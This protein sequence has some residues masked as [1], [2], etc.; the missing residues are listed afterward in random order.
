MRSD[1]DWSDIADHAETQARVLKWLRTLT[2]HDELEWDEDGDVA[3][4]VGSTRLYVR[5]SDD[6][7]VVRVYAPTL[8]EVSPSSAV[9]EELNRLNSFTVFPKWLMAGSTIIAAI[10]LYGSPLLKE[11]FLAAF[12]QVAAIADDF[13]EH[14]Q[15]KLGGRPFFGSLKP[16][17]LA[18]SIPG[19]L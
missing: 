5:V 9:F 12:R 8:I 7:L 18:T 1:S 6:P 14:L 16:V 15:D 2:G 17:T 3:V 11:H 19:Y 10:H 13:D 4:R